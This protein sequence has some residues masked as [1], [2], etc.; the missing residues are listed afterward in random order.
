MLFA[1]LL[2][3]SAAAVVVPPQPKAAYHGLVS[4]DDYPTAARAQH[5]TGTTRVRLDVAPVGRVAACA[6]IASSGAAMLDA[7]T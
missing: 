3:A 1:A 2:A 6:V 7:A 5:L 4:L